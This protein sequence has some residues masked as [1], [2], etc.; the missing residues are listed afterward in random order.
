MVQA[1]Q[2][3]EDREY[4]NDDAL[5][6]TFPTRQQPRKFLKLEAIRGKHLDLCQNN[7]FCIPIVQLYMLQLAVIVMSNFGDRLIFL[8]ILGYYDH[9]LNLN[10]LKMLYTP[11]I[12]VILLFKITMPS[13]LV[14]A[15][16]YC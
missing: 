3:L 7:T 8:D 16:Y 12:S 15:M 6:C 14:T 13:A 1:V 2:T 4:V 10:V 5:P 11:R 9:F